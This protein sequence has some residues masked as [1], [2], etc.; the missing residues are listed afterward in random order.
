MKKLLD[1]KV[2]IIT[3]A[4][5]GIG[6]A[7]AL[8]FSLD[9]AKVVVVDI[10][11][12]AVQETAQLIE[13]QGG[14][15]LAMTI[16]VTSLEAV[17]KMVEDTVTHFGKIDAIF[18]NAGGPITKP[19]G[20]VT[21]EEFQK[22]INLNLASVFYGIKAVLPYFLKQGCGVVLST[23]SGAGLD[24]SPGQGVY[25]AAKAG[26]IALTQTLAA[27]YGTY[28]IRANVISPGPIRSTMF[29]EWLNS[30]PIETKENLI[31]QVPSARFG[32]PEDIAKMA[33]VLISDRASYVNGITIPI[34][35]GIHTRS[36]FHF[37]KPT[38]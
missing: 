36:S 3:G 8:Q 1:D 17:S 19:I 16:D 12:T 18:N 34:D 23:S 9:G 25:G 27:E 4:G 7:S 24:G 15:A 32:V 5:S 13:K 33:A 2:A 10:H 21:A 28:G 38:I 29:D 26:I 20:E 30:F 6:R 31:A 11:T 14:I 35:G 22:L 37:P